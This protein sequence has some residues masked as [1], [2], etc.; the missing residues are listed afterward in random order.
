MT[1]NTTSPTT[2]LQSIYNTVRAHLLKQNAKAVDTTGACR[3][4]TDNGL[5]CA[6]GCLIPD[7]LYKPEMEGFSVDELDSDVLEKLGLDKFIDALYDLQKIHDVKFVSA[8]ETEL[9]NFAAK[10]GLSR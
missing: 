3:Y 4:R 9:N 8:W 5:S 6:I 1:E 10:Y 2:S 7:E